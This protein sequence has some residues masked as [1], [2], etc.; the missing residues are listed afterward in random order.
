[1]ETSVVIAD[2]VPA[3]YKV[4]ESLRSTHGPDG[5]VVMDIAQGRMF[6]LNRV[7]AR[8]LELMKSGAGE[9]EIVEAISQEFE[10]NRETVE[11]DLCDF[12]ATLMRHHLINLA[13]D[14]SGLPIPSV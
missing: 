1:M 11:Q 14:R 10:A 7:G 8:M 6:S 9:S 13:A 12:I 5:A 3:T 2:A 4:C